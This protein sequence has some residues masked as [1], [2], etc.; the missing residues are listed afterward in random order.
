MANRNIYSLYK[1]KKQINCFAKVFKFSA[2]KSVL[3]IPQS[4]NKLLANRPGGNHIKPYVI[5][6]RKNYI[7]YA[8]VEIGEI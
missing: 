5:N 6:T 4:K 7:F 2:L 1:F 8:S 3:Q